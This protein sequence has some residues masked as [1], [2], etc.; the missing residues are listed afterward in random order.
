MAPPLPLKNWWLADDDDAAARQMDTLVETLDA[1]QD[2]RAYDLLLLM[3]M[4]AN[5]D[6]T[7]LAA[8]T[9]D[10]LLD[11]NMPK[12]I[13]NTS[14][15]ILQTLVSEHVESESK[16]TFDVD[17]GDW[18][19][20][21]KAEQLDKFVWGEIYRTDLYSWAEMCFRDAGISGDGWL[22]FMPVNDQVY[23]Q[24]VLPLSMVIDESACLTTPPTEL[25][26]RDY[27]PRSM[28]MELWPEYADVI[29]EA[30]TYT[31]PYA[32]PGT[33]ADLVRVIE[34]WHLTL[35]DKPGKHVIAVAG[36]KVCAEDW[37]HK[38]FPFARMTWDQAVIGGY[39]QGL[40]EILAPL[41]LELNK[42]TKRIQQSLHLMAV[43]RIWQNSATKV[44]ATY[45][46]KLGN[47]YKYTGPKPEIDT[48]PAIQQELYQREQALKEN[49]YTLARANP[50]R[51][52]M[53]TPSR[54]DSRPGFQE[55]IAT[56]DSANAW[57]SKKWER[58]M[59]QCAEQIVR[60]A[61][62]I[63]E[64]NGSYK[65]FGKAKHFIEKIDFKECDLEDDRFMIKVQATNLMPTTIT[66][67]R[68]AFMEMMQLPQFQNDPS[69]V[70]EMMGDHPD[71]K[72]MLKQKN[73]PRELIEK[74]LYYICCKQEYFAPEQYQDIM[75][76]RQMAMNE[77]QLQY[78]NSKGENTKVLSLLQQYLKDLDV[79]DQ[80]LNPP[81]P[82]APPAPQGMMPN[83][84]NPQQPPV[85]GIP[86]PGGGIPGVQ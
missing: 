72:G 32:W 81:A 37:D 26:Q 30:P 24:R 57:I 85:P 33:E 36:I 52:G 2:G 13:I 54:V 29:A 61:R 63:V 70:L 35:D 25:Y 51:S 74:Q 15:S 62:D 1:Q 64:R 38:C 9:G 43:P 46:N 41:Q 56:A 73:A 59:V 84:G 31:P 50:V 55:Y 4:Y 7:S 77:W 82:P 71:L 68:M 18:E 83:A 3:S 16:P 48:A 12:Q 23:I 11:G 78:M 5:K 44:G 76:A 65:A 58:F 49:M 39:S 53:N 42:T 45:D 10:F 86:G 60:V 28:A 67:K 17:D 66:G 22:K 27:Y 14:A 69:A 47:V 79:I 34:G 75:L 80:L 21:V 8:S 19:A 20:K 40:M 6:L